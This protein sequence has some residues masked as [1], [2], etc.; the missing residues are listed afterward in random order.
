MKE[1]IEVDDNFSMAEIII[2]MR[3]Y[4]DADRKKN[5]FV[6]DLCK[7]C[8]IKMNNPNFW[9]V[10]NY[11]KKIKVFIPGEAFG[12]YS[13]YMLKNEELLAN[14]V[15]NQNKFEVINKFIEDSHTVVL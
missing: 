11:L 3:L 10:F 1:K 9:T 5:Y 6:K 14:L 8:D 13:R 12:K 4:S 7:A 15:M 2:M